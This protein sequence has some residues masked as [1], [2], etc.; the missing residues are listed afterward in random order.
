MTITAKE[1]TAF[2][3]PK[4]PGHDDQS[5]LDHALANGDVTVFKAIG[6]NR[7]RTGKSEHCEYWTDNSKVIL[8]GGSPELKDSYKGVTRGQQLTYFGDD[9]RLIVDGQVKKL[10]FTEMKKK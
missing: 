2:L 8:S 10:A 5:S 4:T 9:D 1:L 3:T 7:T 6:P